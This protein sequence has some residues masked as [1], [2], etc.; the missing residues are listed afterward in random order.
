MFR[1][2]TARPAPAQPERSCTPPLPDVPSELGEP[3]AGL[4]TVPPNETSCTASVAAS[5][6][7]PPSET[8]VDAAM[9]ELTDKLVTAITTINPV[10]SNQIYISNFD[11]SLNDFDVWYDRECLARVGN[12][13]KGNARLWLDEVDS[14]SILFNVM[15]TSPD[16]YPTYAEYA[17]RS[18]L[19]LRIVNGLSEELIS[20]IIIRGICDP[21][22]RAAATNA[23]LLPGDLV[24]F[25]SI[26]I[27]SD[28]T[29]QAR[30]RPRV[31]P[32]RSN[33]LY[34]NSRKRE[35]LSGPRSKCFT[36]GNFGHKQYDCPKRLKLTDGIDKSQN[37]DELK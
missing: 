3:C 5:V 12:C 14:A 9:S 22:I 21:L 25:L 15:K 18:V 26:Y 23:N 30:A 35:Y 6:L 11:P 20:A 33:D 13:L 31:V 2:A 19:R 28:R 37:S 29:E 36:C 34:V 8:T 4:L 27:K 24:G 10:R 17:R 32:G 7:P 1:H 16:N